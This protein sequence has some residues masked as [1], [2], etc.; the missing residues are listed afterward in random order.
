MNMTNRTKAALLMLLSC[1]SFALM[2]LTVKLSALTIGTMEQVF[3]RNLIGLFLSYA[4]LKQNHLPLF[5]AKADRVPILTR[6]FFGFCG[7]VFLFLATANAKQADVSMLSRTTPIWVSIFSFIFLKEKISKVQIPVILLCMVGAAV[8]IRP[9]FDSSVWPLLFA[10]ATA[11]CSGVAYTAIA[12]CK[13]RVNPL[14]VI[15]NFCLFSTLAA[16]ILMVPTFVVPTGKNLVYLLL[17]GLFGAAGQLG[18]TYAM[19]KAPASET[20]VYDYST[21]IISALLGYFVLGEKLTA[22]T[23][24][25]STLIIAGGMW[26]YWYN[27]FCSKGQE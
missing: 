15:F 16:G 14:T 21:I 1:L 2:Q 17:I 23:I 9:S 26:S 20:S 24:I 6:C 18:L 27:R 19:Q 4:L 8:A 10:V 25:G 13:G 11:V 22:T 3:S 7:M 5:C 12:Y